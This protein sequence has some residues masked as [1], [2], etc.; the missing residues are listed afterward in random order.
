MSKRVKGI[1]SISEEAVTKFYIQ[2]VPNIHKYIIM[3]IKIR[4]RRRRLQTVGA[5]VEAIEEDVKA[6]QRWL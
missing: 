6:I 3:F 2:F 5:H 1:P 4:R